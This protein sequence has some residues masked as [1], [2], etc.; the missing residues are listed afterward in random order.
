[1]IYK[2]KV[3]LYNLLKKIEIYTHGYTRVNDILEI[4]KG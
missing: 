4:N 3:I 1:M 2:I